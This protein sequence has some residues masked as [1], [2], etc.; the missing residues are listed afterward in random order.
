MWAGFSVLHELELADEVQIIGGGGGRVKLE[1]LG[2]MM[3][4]MIDE[5]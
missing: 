4:N 2:S 5:C 1:V 3:F